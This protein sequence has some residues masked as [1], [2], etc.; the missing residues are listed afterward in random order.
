M[1]AFFK[2][3]L[4]NSNCSSLFAFFVEEKGRRSL[5]ILAENKPSREEKWVS[6]L[7][8]RSLDAQVL[9]NQTPSK[10]TKDA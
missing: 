7:P 8:Y 10:R 4:F 5:L 2:G 6:Q 1:R 9:D 3:K